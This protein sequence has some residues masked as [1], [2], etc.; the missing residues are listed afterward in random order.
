MS[1]DDAVNSTVIG[2]LSA[3][4][5][6]DFSGDPDSPWER[7]SDSSANESRQA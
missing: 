3:G 6:N 4:V 7:A 2:T 5:P 1:K